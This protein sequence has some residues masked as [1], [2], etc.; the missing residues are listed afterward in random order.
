MIQG[1]EEE[2]SNSRTKT[3][4]AR[5]STLQGNAGLLHG[6]SKTYNAQI[7]F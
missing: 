7:W 5:L 3:G 6:P 4:L 1:E 2:T